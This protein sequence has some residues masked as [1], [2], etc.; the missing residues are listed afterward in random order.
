MLS[1][2]QYSFLPPKLCLDETLSY[3]VRT[4]RLIFIVHIGALDNILAPTRTHIQ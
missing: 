3:A 1:R 4:M 2:A